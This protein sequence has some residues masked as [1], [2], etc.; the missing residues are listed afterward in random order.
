MGDGIAE[1]GGRPP[2]V[3]PFPRGVG[4]LPEGMMMAGASSSI[5]PL[6]WISSSCPPSSEIELAGKEPGRGKKT[7]R[8]REC[9]RE[10]RRECLAAVSA[11][12]S[13]A[14]C[15][16]T[17]IE[18]GGDVGEERV[19][20]LGKEVDSGEARGRE[21]GV[22]MERVRAWA[23]LRCVGGLVMEKEGRSGEAVPFI[24]T[25]GGRRNWPEEDGMSCGVE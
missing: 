20:V 24:G 13:G 2:N 19:G 21:N 11:E 25:L 12:V 15:D 16:V 4:G 10:C 1:L 9:I 8:L 14:E 3:N 18:G 23:P 5:G 17:M 6:W 7:D 22:E